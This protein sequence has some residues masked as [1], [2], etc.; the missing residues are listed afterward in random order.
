[1]K[2]RV[3]YVIG[4]FCIFILVGCS[5][6]VKLN[7]QKVQFIYN[8][9]A[10]VAET[11]IDTVDVIISGNKSDVAL[12]AKNGR[13][14]ARLSELEMDETKT[15]ILEFESDVKGVKVKIEPSKIDVTLR[16]KVSD[17][18]DFDYDIVNEDELDE[19]LSVG[20]VVFNKESVIVRG[21]QET[22]NNIDSVKVLL[23]VSVLDLNGA[24]EY[25]LDNL[26]LVAYDDEGKVIENVEIVGKVSA[27]IK[28]DSYSKLVPVKVQTVG[29][30]QNGK[31]ISSIMIDGLSEK[32]VTIYGSESALASINMLEVFVDIEGLGNSDSKE[33]KLTISKPNGV[34]AIDTEY[35][36]VKMQFGEAKQMTVTIPG[37]T[38][39]NLSNGLAA[40]LVYVEDSSVEVKVIGTE[41]ILN[42]LD[43]SCI[44]AYVDLEGLDVG[45]HN[46]EI[47]VESSDSRLQFVVT[48]KINIVIAKK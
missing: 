4:F 26:E 42:N 6:K 29:E 36:T 39:K 37:I 5:N 33:Y 20:S 27:K 35:L 16:A 30:L 8:D 40:S 32:N 15:I 18:F 38:T 11:D 28:V 10:Y 23:D 47:E 14:I 45:T 34:R 13:V 3:L 25:D 7:D 12:A 9:E 46:V 31:A 21:T 43:I 17:A 19:R 1:M 41:D 24:G 48:R 22:L 2:K 44:N